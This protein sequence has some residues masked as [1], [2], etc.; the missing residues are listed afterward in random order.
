MKELISIII[1]NRVGEINAT[2][3]SIERQTYKN[4]EVIEVIDKNSKGA[5]WARNEGMKKAK[6]KYIFFCD[7]DLELKEDCLM[8]L[9]TAL[10]EDKK[11]DWA[12]G[13]FNISGSIH[14]ANKGPMPTDKKSLEFINWFRGI[15]TM[16]LIRAKCKP[17]FDTEF[18]RYND[19]EL[20]I[21]LVKAGHYP[22]FCNKFL[23]RT[24]YR[25]GGISNQDAGDQQIWQ[26]RLYRKHI[27]KVADIV[28]PHHDKHG[29]LATCLSKLN[30]EIFNIIVVAGGSFA[31]NCNKGA[32][33]AKTKNIIFLNDDTEPSTEYLMKMVKEDSDITGIAQLVRQT[34]NIKY[35]I[36]IEIGKNEIYKSLSASPTTTT[37][38]S[39]FCFKVKKAAWKKLK[40]LDERYINGGEDVDLFLRAMELDMSFG[41]IHTPIRHLLSQ[42]SGRFTFAGEN[43]T[44]FSKLWD[45]KLRKGKL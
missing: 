9:Y 37:M 11:A 13:T 8:S 22:V 21:R 45:D 26:Q 2:L 7:N 25:P 33:I 40:G 29:M 19:W 43:D 28:I 35:G 34:N 18:K 15:S 42:S 3:D 23:F 27:G 38:P 17:K 44:L 4:Y 1:P 30:N 16:S 41:Y 24:T 14:N 12:F 32:K 6:G 10:Q 39:G 36:N 20:W 31:E 5:S